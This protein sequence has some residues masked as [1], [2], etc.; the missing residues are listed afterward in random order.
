MPLKIYKRGDTWHYRGSV[1]GQRLRGSCKTADKAIA[2]RQIAEIEARQWKCS[3]DGP[4]AVLTFAQAASLYRAAGK[5]TRFLAKVEDQFRNT[6]VRDIKPGM[7]RQ[8][9]IDLYPGCSGSGMNRMGIVPAQ[10]VINHAA[11]SEL[12]QP[13]RVRRFKV[14]ARIKE[15]VTLEWVRAL[16]AHA[17][18]AIGGLALFMFLT[19]ARIGEAIGLQWD[20]IELTKGTALIRESKVGNERLAHLPVPL[21]VAVA[22]IPMVK[23]RGVFFYQHPTDITKAWNGAIKRAGI[24]KLS[25]HSCRHGFATGL[26]RKGI[27]VHTVAELGGWRGPTQVLKTYGHAIRNRKLTDAL[28]TQ[29][30]MDNSRNPMK[31]GTT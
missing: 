17:S 16:Q 29:D 4:E 13:I 15:P 27:D 5:S 7:I 24:K 31:T 9:A 2:A 12:C 11:E 26:L 14:D 8:M 25:P 23:G 10:A 20:E 6:L 18:P 22:N 21:V 28:L 19:G 30:A 1:A 3:F